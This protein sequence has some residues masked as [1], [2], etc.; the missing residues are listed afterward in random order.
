M[1]FW[2]IV[3]VGGGGVRLILFPNCHWLLPAC[4][5]AGH[6][7][8]KGTSRHYLPRIWFLKIDQLQF[9]QLENP[10]HL[11]FDIVVAGLRRLPF[12]RF[13]RFSAHSSTPAIDVLNA[14]LPF[15]PNNRIRA[16][17]S[18]EGRKSINHILLF[19]SVHVALAWS[20]VFVGLRPWNATIL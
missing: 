14:I 20:S 18:L 13:N 11:S 17:G 10:N 9:D 19:V 15:Y 3:S 2:D 1:H 6:E 7:T 4:S 12:K 8:T 5:T 16:A